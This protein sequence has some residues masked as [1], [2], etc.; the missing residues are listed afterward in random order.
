MKR[1]R[2]TETQVVKILKEAERRDLVQY[3]VA[4]HQ[5]SERQAC[6]MLNLSRSVYRYQAKPS[7]DEELREQLLSLASRT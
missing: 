3:A 6:A 7:D 2:F 1:S 5:M 4:T